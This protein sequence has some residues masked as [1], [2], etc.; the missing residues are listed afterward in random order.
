MQ[1]SKINKGLLC[2]I[3]CHQNKKNS[4]KGHKTALNSQFFSVEKDINILTYTMWSW[5]I[6]IHYDLTDNYTYWFY[7]LIIY[8]PEYFQ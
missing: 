5:I 6:L 1:L 8:D 4:Q 3:N 2:I 7:L